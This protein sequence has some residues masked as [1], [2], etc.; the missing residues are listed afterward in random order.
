[1]PMKTTDELDVLCNNKWRKFI[2]SLDIADQVAFLGESTR[3]VACK[4]F[5][6]GYIMGGKDVGD[7]YSDGLNKLL[8]KHG[9]E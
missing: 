3:V 1:M 2:E 9:V 8:Q 6:K 4:F 5:R 7:M